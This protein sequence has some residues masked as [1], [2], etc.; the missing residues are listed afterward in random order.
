MHPED[1]DSKE[2]SRR[3]RADIRQVSLDILDP[4]GIKDEP[5]AQ[6]EYDGYIGRLNELLIRR[7]PDSELANYLYEVAHDRMGF[8]T[9]QIRDM[10]ETGQAL[11]RIKLPWSKT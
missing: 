10:E 4:I 9:A 6:D 1:S 2:E 11:K 5:N 8:D 3:I 7:A